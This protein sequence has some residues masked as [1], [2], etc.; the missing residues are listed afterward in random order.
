MTLRDECGYASILVLG[1]AL[2][3]IAV[4]GVAIDGTRAFLFR[5]SL[6]NSADAAALAGASEIDRRMYYESEGR[7]VTIDPQ[8]AEARAAEWLQRRGIGA[9]AGISTTDRSVRVVLR[10][11]LEMTFLRVI[12]LSSTRVGAES[13]A[14]PRAG[15]L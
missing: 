6:Q 11:E 15:A 12:G 5:R 3:A 9:S 1:F 2:I 4:T 7:A 14:E 10:A 8:R 13:T